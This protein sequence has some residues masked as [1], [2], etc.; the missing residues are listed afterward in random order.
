MIA[1]SSGSAA[2]AVDQLKRFLVTRGAV[3]QG[4][5]KRIERGDIFRVGDQDLAQIGFG[6]VDAVAPLPGQATRLEERIV[7]RIGG[8]P[9]R[10]HIQ[11][12]GIVLF[13]LFQFR[14]QQVSSTP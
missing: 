5:A 12:A 9:A 7:V 1:A 13:L 10:Q 6:A 11:F 3:G 8:K 2:R 4:V 14:F